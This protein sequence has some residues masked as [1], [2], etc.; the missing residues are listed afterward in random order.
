MTRKPLDQNEFISALDFVKTDIDNL[1]AYFE[2]GA[3][4]PTPAV[5]ERAL[6]LR[7]SIEMFVAL[8]SGAPQNDANFSTAARDLMVQSQIL[9]KQNAEVLEELKKAKEPIQSTILN[10]VLNVKEMLIKQGLQGGSN[11]G[12][13]LSV[14]SEIAQLK[15]SLAYSLSELE[16]KLSIDIENNG[17]N[18]LDEYTDKMLTEVYRMQKP[19]NQVGNNS[20]IL[21]EIAQLKEELSKQIAGV[22]KNVIE[23]IETTKDE[24]IYS[25]K[26]DEILKGIKDNA[27]DI[28]Q[29][30]V[31]AKTSMQVLR[32]ISK[33]L[34]GVYES[35]KR[36]LADIEKAVAGVS[37]HGRIASGE[38]MELAEGFAE[39]KEELQNISSIINFDEIEKISDPNQALEVAD[40]I[41]NQAFEPEGLLQT[42]RELE[43]L[44]T[45]LSE[46][47][48]SQAE[49]EAESEI[50]SETDE[51]SEL[52]NFE[53]E[54]DELE[55]LD[56][57]I[58]QYDE[59]EKEFE[60]VE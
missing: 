8:F 31:L 60:T 29:S 52:D 4:D 50:T 46:L 39:L 36:A 38:D 34:L 56:G 17:R 24:I 26:S 51:L 59:A 33:Q 30:I 48:K 28:N 57:E 7:V 58:P 37:Y 41:A 47:E 44:A 12:S 10:E 9:A 6:K 40:S 21:G 20:E 14:G 1:R 19:S 54:T 18:Q 43:A 3:I 2:H 11:I 42:A 5:M 15:A 32:G 27:E 55:K 22:E 49:R 16:Q 13:H 35:Q 25:Q 23:N 45:E 53:E